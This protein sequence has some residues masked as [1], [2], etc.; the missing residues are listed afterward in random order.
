MNI[1]N[2]KL[3]IK[4]ADVRYSDTDKQIRLFQDF[5]TG[6]YFEKFENHI[7]QNG[8]HSNRTASSIGLTL[9]DTTIRSGR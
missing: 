6:T 5:T 8:K 3:F 2:P 9:D 4:N 7:R 1:N